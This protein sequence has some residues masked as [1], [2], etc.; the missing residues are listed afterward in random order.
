MRKLK[1]SNKLRIYAW[2]CCHMGTFSML[3]W[4]KS[5]S[6]WWILR[7]PV[8]QSFDVF[9]DVRIQKCCKNTSHLS[10][11]M[12]CTKSQLEPV[13]SVL[14]ITVM[15]VTSNLT[16]VQQLVQTNIRG[17]PPYWSLWGKLPMTGGFPSQRASNAEI[18]SM[19]WRHHVSS[20]EDKPSINKETNLAGFLSTHG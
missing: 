10:W 4:S 14:I 1:L 5:T 3:L 6:R 12:F 15:S 20:W 17:S 11:N 8:M 19:L 9:F 18:I 7:G 16:F 13:Q 2:R